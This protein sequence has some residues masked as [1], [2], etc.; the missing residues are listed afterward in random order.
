MQGALESSV[1]VVDEY[2]IFHVRFSVFWCA[3]YLQ[4]DLRKF[5]EIGRV[6]N[7]FHL[8]RYGGRPL[9]DV[10]PVDVLEEWMQFDL[11]QTGARL[12]TGYA[13]ARTD[14]LFGLTAELHN[15]ITTFE[16]N[17]YFRWKD[18]GLA[19]VHYLTIGLLRRFTSRR[20]KVEVVSVKECEF[21]SEIE[22]FAPQ[23]A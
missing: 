19:P 1:R 8:D 3:R 17:R 15:Q 16:R 13:I 12:L 14:A 18:E 4:I 23:N 6:V 2:P 22:L 20:M 21:R 10:L 5:I 9:S 7:A 11:L